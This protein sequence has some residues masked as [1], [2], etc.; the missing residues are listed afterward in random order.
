MSSKIAC[1]SPNIVSQKGDVAGTGIPYFP[2]GLVYL[3]TYL[4]EQGR[5][6][7]F[8]DSFSEKPFQLKEHHGFLYQGLT[9]EE[10]VKRLE[11]DV[12]ICI[13]YAGQ[14][15]AH[16]SILEIAKLLKKKGKTVLVVENAQA[17]TAYSLQ[18]AYKDFFAAG[19]DYLIS[20][21]PEPRIFGLLDVIEKNAKPESVDGL[22]WK[23]GEEVV[24]NEKKVFQDVD[25]LPFPDWSLLNLKNYWK[26]HYAHA[27]LSRKKYLPLLTSRGCPLV[28]A[29]CVTP[30]TNGHKWRPRNAVNVVDEI[31][32]N[33]KK[34]GV[35]EF[36]LEDLNPTV[37]KKR[38]VEISKEILKRNLIVDLK[39][40]S[41]TKA[42]TYTI[43][44]IRWMAKAGFSYFSIS[45]ESGSPRVLRLMKKYF[46][47]DFALKQVREM[48]KLKTYSQACFVLGFP[49][50]TEEDLKMTQQYVK[51]LTKAGVDEIALFI[52]T[53][54]PGSQVYTSITKGYEDISRLT[55]TPSWRPEYK[56][57]AKWRKKIVLTFLWTKLLYH[58]INLFRQGLRV[59]IGNYKTKMEMTLNRLLKTHLLFKKT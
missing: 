33:V 19:V 13:L 26:I 51:A 48:N 20:G 55:F 42:E 47:H 24:L 44:T 57:L 59:F 8:I 41:G 23:N 56:E 21:D 39:F 10:I 34:Y 25:V 12:E 15:Y 18:H 38:M 46:D 30:A 50:E 7:Q 4:R 53:P 22:I 17:V 52:M 36:H 3:A 45:P 14:V 6:I 49:G 31:E 2:F 1:I 40:A 32:Y 54:V 28:C 58:P 29:F 16:T 9:P 11:K 35:T 43:D 5:P 27:P 37:K